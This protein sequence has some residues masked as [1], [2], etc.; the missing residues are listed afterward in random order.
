[1]K[2]IFLDID[3]VMVP[4]KSW[5]SPELLNDGFLAFSS[6]SVNVL[7]RFI[8]EQLIIVLTSSH[9]SNYSTEEWKVIFKLRGLQVFNVECLI[10]N[11]NNLSRLEEVVNWF[12]AND[13][14]E[15]FVIIDDDKSLN[16]LPEELKNH[17][18]QTSSTLG[19]VERHV[20]EIQLILKGS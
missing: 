2:Y 15:K 20:E 16:S 10:E 19:L 9:K 4:A 6:Q 5:K 7:K 18:V 17:L 3:G 8:E 14:P 1:M 12:V 13:T 11:V